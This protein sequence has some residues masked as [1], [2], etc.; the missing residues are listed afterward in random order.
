MISSGENVSDLLFQLYR[1]DGAFPAGR[2]RI[3]A[4]EQ[5]VQAVVCDLRPQ[6]TGHELIGPDDIGDQLQH[7]VNTQLTKPGRVIF[8]E[9]RVKVQVHVII[10]GKLVLAEQVYETVHG[11]IVRWNGGLEHLLVAENAL[12]ACGPV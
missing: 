5:P 12:Q 6:V 7:L 11:I 4:V 3:E 2:D 1:I 8:I 9:P 10:I